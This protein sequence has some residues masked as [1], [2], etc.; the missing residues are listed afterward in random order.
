MEN[1]SLN[2]SYT[3]P[4]QSITPSLILNQQDKIIYDFIKSFKGKWVSQQDIINFRGKDE[5]RTRKLLQMLEYNGI[6]QSKIIK[7]KDEVGTPFRKLW[8]I[9]H[10]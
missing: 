9:K 2:G 1:D 8:N 3:V 10:K 4:K 5:R 6:L 7:I